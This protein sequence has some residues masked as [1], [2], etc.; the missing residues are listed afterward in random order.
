[1]SS[2]RRLHC[3]MLSL[4]MLGSVVTVLKNGVLHFDISEMVR[5]LMSSWKDRQT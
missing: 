4:I 2:S 5:I 1:M 3:T